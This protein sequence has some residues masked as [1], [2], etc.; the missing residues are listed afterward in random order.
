M[1]RTLLVSNRLPIVLQ[2]QDEHLDIQAASGGLATALSGI[3]QQENSLWIG[4]PGPI[5]ALSAAQQAHVERILTERRL[6][7]VPLSADEVR[8]YYDRFSNGVL[9]PLCHYLLD[10]LQLDAQ[11][12]WE[13]YQAVN[14]RFAEVIVANYQPGD[15]IWIHDYQLALVPQKVR[16]RLPTATIGF[17]LHI[18]FPST[19]VFRILPWREALLTGLLGADLV[20]FHTAVY[21]YHF[22]YATSRLLGLEPSV[23]E[24]R[25]EDR[26]VQIGAFPIGIDGESFA[27]RAASL[28]V[29]DA[30]H[31]LRQH[32]APRKIILGVDRLDYTKGIP[33]R[34]A[35]IA[36][37]LEKRPDLRDQFHFIQIA[38]PSREL[39]TS[40]VEHRQWVN[41]LVGR[42]N[43]EFGSPQSVP[44]YLLH[45]SVSPIELSALYCAADVMLVT[46]LRD[47]MN[48]VAKEYV[49]SRIDERGVLVLSEFAGAAGSL[50]EALIVNPYDTDATAATI[51]RALHMSPPEQWLRMTALRRRVMHQSATRWAESFLEALSEAAMPVATS[52]PQPANLETLTELLI[53]RMETGGLALLLDY[54]GTLVPFAPLPEL[55]TPSVELLELLQQ[56]TQLPNTAVHI[57]SGRPREFLEQH[58]GHLPLGLHAEH[59]FWSRLHQD[60]AWVAHQLVD[61]HWKDAARTRLT[62]WVTRTEGSLLEEKSA[63]LAWHYRN[64][65]P[66]LAAQRVREARMQ[67]QDFLPQFPQIELLEGSKVM[68]LRL[69]GINKGIVVAKI[70]AML[71]AGCVTVA[72]GDDRTDEDLFAALPP[73]G[74]AIHIGRGTTQA[75]YRLPHPN[76]LALLL[77]KLVRNRT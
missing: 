51:E 30:L 16:A 61:M 35:A 38:V 28:E 57:V 58:L 74:V 7:A 4:W 48:L 18:P 49:A 34:L 8:H 25:F 77:H 37:L 70:L 20:G 52:T 46:P 15:R 10:K 55:A 1:S 11:T 56:V 59:G 67:L 3:H 64:T 62:R 14:E 43:G 68:E 17:F 36:R 29:A 54:D 63:S 69:R 45:Q 72:V 71:P 75:R 31:A 13:I 60:D 41:E 42:I 22:G 9:W 40:Y 6:I 47:G 65:E 21:A 73:S 32:H 53:G 33:Q 66:Q 76:D 44:I 23:D 2:Q 5:Y 50:H 24:L 39:V 27:Q 19:E 26:H 12:D